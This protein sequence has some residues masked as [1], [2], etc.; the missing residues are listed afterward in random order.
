MI[1]LQGKFILWNVVLF[2]LLF[3]IF[4]V[5][6]PFRRETRPQILWRTGTTKTK[7]EID[8]SGNDIQSN[9]DSISKS[10]TESSDVNEEVKSQ[11]FDFDSNPEQVSIILFSKLS[12]FT[13][14]SFDRCIISLTA[15]RTKALEKLE[16]ITAVD[17]VFGDQG[18]ISPTFYAQLLRPQISKAPKRRWTQA[19]FFAFG[20]FMHKSC[21]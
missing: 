21:V 10:L 12:P 7:E 6:S 19:G 11:Q 5:I 8:A 9:N 4:L 13:F 20:I 3:L 15:T 14:Y 18:S 16:K 1:H 17:V 2:L